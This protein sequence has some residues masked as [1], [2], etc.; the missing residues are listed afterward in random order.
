MEN[1][2][3]EMSLFI[4]FKNGKFKLALIVLIL[5]IPF[6]YYNSLNKLAAEKKINLFLKSITEKKYNFIC[7][8]FYDFNVQYMNQTKI[9]F[10]KQRRWRHFKSN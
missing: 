5:V 8:F 7:F 2:W 4:Y 10:A 1:I 3:A 9:L 6:Y